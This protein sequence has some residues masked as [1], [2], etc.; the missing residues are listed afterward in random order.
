[1]RYLK[2]Y[3][4]YSLD[5]KKERVYLVNQCG[6]IF[7]DLIHD[8]SSIDVSFPGKKTFSGEPANI[9]RIIFNDR[10][11]T[12]AYVPRTSFNPLKYIDAFYHLDSFLQSRGYKYFSDGS[13]YDTHEKLMK[14]FDIDVDLLLLQINYIKE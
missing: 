6:D 7:Y 1:M 13:W 8:G 3:E 14:S 9:L 2:A 12:G 5:E 4:S 10:T 11:P